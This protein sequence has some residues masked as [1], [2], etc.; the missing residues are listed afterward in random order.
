MKITTPFHLHG[1]SGHYR[2]MK[3][4]RHLLTGF[5][6]IG[7]LVLLMAAKARPQTDQ[8]PLSAGKQI[9]SEKGCA[10]CH[11]IQG[12]GGRAAADLSQVGGK[13]DRRWLKQFMAA[14]RAVMPQAK[15]PPFKGSLDELDALVSYLG[16]LK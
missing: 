1:R 4:R 12:K 2:N 9:Y 10:L 14:P 5:L 11:A 16:S 15:M 6:T 3:A 7:V 13:R 8:D